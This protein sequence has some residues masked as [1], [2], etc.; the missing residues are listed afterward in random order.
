[1]CHEHTPYIRKRGSMLKSTISLPGLAVHWS[2]SEVDRTTFDITLIDKHNKEVYG[3]VKSNLAGGPAI[4]FHWFC[5][6]TFQANT[7]RIW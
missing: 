6:K 5:E 4:V 3:T 2:Y 7:T 1:M